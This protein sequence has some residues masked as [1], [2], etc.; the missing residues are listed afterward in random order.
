MNHDKSRDLE[1]ART[2]EGT[3][4][5]SVLKTCV[6]VLILF[7]TVGMSAD[8]IGPL[9]TALVVLYQVCLGAAVVAFILYALLHWRTRRAIR[10]LNDPR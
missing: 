9:P 3:I 7:G 8:L 10:R 4:R 5:A 2:I 1:I 6:V